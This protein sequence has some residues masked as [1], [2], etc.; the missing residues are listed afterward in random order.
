MFIHVYVYIICMHICLKLYVHIYIYT[1]IHIYVYINIC[2]HIHIFFSL[3]TFSNAFLGM[4][5]FIY[6]FINSRTNIS[7]HIFPITVC[8]VGLRVSKNTVALWGKRIHHVAISDSVVL[9]LADTG[10]CYCWGGKNQ[11]WDAIQPGLYA[12]CC[13]FFLCLVISYRLSLRRFCNPMSSF[14]FYLSRHHQYH[15]QLKFS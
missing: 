5:I 8:M 10:E 4:N 1:Y 12:L 13:Y 11:W 3:H 15:Y 2:V 7:I 14:N 9:A 6:K